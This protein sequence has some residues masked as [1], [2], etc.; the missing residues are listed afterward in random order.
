VAGGPGDRLRV[1]VLPD[2]DAAV[3]EAVERSDQVVQH[4]DRGGLVAERGQ[5]HLTPHAA[6]D[7]LVE[8]REATEGPD[9][10][11]DWPHDDGCGQGLAEHLAGDTCVLVG[12]PEPVG[13]RR[14]QGLGVGRVDRVLGVGL[15]EVFE[16]GLD[17][18][19][20]L[21]RGLVL[22]EQGPRVV[23]VRDHLRELRR[24]RLELR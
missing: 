24:L 18:L 23:D 6:G 13:P 11:A 19:H 2:D 16:L 9:A 10:L 17:L 3:A 12:L 22:G 14:L 15:R 8:L 5:R 1:R 20:A 21:L 4:P 7:D